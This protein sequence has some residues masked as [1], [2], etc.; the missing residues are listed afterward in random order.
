MARAAT[1]GIVGGYGGPM[2]FMAELR[3]AGIEQTEIF[4][5]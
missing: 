1:F 3:N 4:T 2:A 5:P